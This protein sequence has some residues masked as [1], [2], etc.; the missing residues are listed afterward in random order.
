MSLL[1]VG[2]MQDLNQLHQAA[3][4]QQA[5][6]NQKMS[7]IIEF[8][9]R[10]NKSLNTIRTCQNLSERLT[11]TKINKKKYIENIVNN[12]WCQA[13]VVVTGVAFIALGLMTIYQ[14]V[15]LSHAWINKQTSYGRYENFEALIFYSFFSFGLAFAAALAVPAVPIVLG[16]VSIIGGTYLTFFPKHFLMSFAPDDQVIE[17]RIQTIRGRLMSSLKIQPDELDNFLHE[18]T[19]IDNETDQENYLIEHLNSLP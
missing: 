8:N 19:L 18:I 3:I 7:Q 17:E 15:S 12:R 9:T 13:A 16:A 2:N 14:A 5:E 10:I 11:T 6:A 1:S 4:Q